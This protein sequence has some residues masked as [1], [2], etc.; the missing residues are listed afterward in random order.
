M[1]TTSRAIPTTPQEFL[2]W[3]KRQRLRYELVSGAAR[4]MI[5][6]TVGRN[7]LAG[8]VLAA[9][10]RQLR[11]GC[12]AHQS[13]LKVV[14]PAGM[15]TYPDVLV[16]CGPID[17]D[18]TEIDDP[19]LI[20]EILSPSTRR[21]DLIRKRY[22]YQAIRSLLWLLHVEPKK[23]QV[24]VVSREADDSWRSV[25]VTDHA[26]TIKLEQLG[27]EFHLAELYAGMA[28]AS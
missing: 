11:P 28:A 15:V 16:R 4:A 25:L 26:A 1:M 19:I 5:G 14:S 6:G 7:L 3:E 20:V 12:T 2:I 24:E 21:E 17:E 10:L 23:V 18:A 13:D 27:V 9:L 8:R 22:R